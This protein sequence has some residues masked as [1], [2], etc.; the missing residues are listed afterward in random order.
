MIMGIVIMADAVYV[1]SLPIH[2]ISHGNSHAPTLQ[3][4]CLTT[5]IGPRGKHFSNDE[6]SGMSLG[7][8]HYLQEVI[9]QGL[10]SGIFPKSTIKGKP[11]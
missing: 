3:G 6:T 7:F 5:F 1:T 10:N 9:N 8:Q 4:L 11:T 2:S